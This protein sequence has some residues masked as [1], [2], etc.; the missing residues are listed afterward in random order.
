M[1]DRQRADV[2]L[3]RPANVNEHHDVSVGG[4]HGVQ[5]GR[6]IG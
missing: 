5:Q 6:R 1:I 3:A 4:R 2:A